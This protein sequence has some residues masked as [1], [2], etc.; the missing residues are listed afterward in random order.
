MVD[1]V[2]RI[3]SVMIPRIQSLVLSDESDDDLWKPS[4]HNTTRASSTSTSR[5]ASPSKER[6]ARC[7]SA[8]DDDEPGDGSDASGTSVEGDS[9]DDSEYSDSS[10]DSS[11]VESESGDEEIPAGSDQSDNEQSAPR[12]RTQGRVRKRP[13]AQCVAEYTQESKEVSDSGSD[14]EPLAQ[15]I[16][17]IQARAPSASS[18]TASSSST[19]PTSTPV[20]AGLDALGALGAR[21]FKLF[22]AN[23]ALYDVRLLAVKHKPLQRAFEFVCDHVEAQRANSVSRQEFSEL[24]TALNAA[25]S[26]LNATRHAAETVNEAQR[27]LAERAF[28][29][30]AQN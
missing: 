23:D 19:A 24:F 9:T 13:L 15:R 30:R 6:N 22:G 8:S 5:S 26:A 14:G 27:K 7:A 16:S 21:L 10:E 2:R 17:K 12:V 1:L 28:G 11:L 18:T 4:L 25:Q 20:D 29:S 3:V